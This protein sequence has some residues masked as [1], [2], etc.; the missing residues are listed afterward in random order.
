MFGIMYAYSDFKYFLWFIKF[1]IKLFILCKISLLND[2]TKEKYDQL[3]INKYKK[4]SY[5]FHT[6]HFM[7]NL[8]HLVMSL[9]VII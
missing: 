9:L 2:I 4:W 6:T 1:D 5:D 7:M 3:K 8:C